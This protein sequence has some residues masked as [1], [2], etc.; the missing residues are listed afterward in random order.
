MSAHILQIDSKTIPVDK[1][2]YLRNLEDWSDSVAD[3]LADAEDIA[4]SPAHWEILHLLRRFYDE[5]QLSP[6]NRAL[7][8]L[9][10]RELGAKKGRSLYLMQLFRS[11]PARLASKLAG[12][13]KPD[14]CL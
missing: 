14:N 9:V 11:N 12:L 8:N 10:K 3:A 1:E 5:H 4:L 13:P 6:A 7:T 2:G